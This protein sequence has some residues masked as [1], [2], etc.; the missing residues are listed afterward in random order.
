MLTTVLLAVV[1]I[2]WS[3]QLLERGIKGGEGFMMFAGALI[4]L[5]AVAVF[6]VHALLARIF[7]I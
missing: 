5:T 4:A 6:W 7:T 3:L 1:L 2:L